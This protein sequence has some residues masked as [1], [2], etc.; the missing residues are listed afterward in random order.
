[1]QKKVLGLMIVLAV[2]LAACVPAA[3]PTAAPA[4]PAAPAAA[5]EAPAA[6]AA[7]AAATEAP[8]APAAPAA[9]VSV[10]KVGA[11]LPLTGGDA[12]NGQ[13]QQQAH[14]LAIEEINAAGGIAC[15]NGAKLEMVYGDSQGKPEAGNSETERL[16]TKEGVVAVMGAFHTGV[17]LT[18]SE[19]AERYEVPFIVPNSDVSARNLKYVFQPA[20]SIESMAKDFGCLCQG[21]G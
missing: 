9:E 18:A 19:V 20:T 12:I 21:D 1:M 4:A 5:T 6:P 7:P 17:T 8:A 11:L 13:S 3:T 2:M 16:I 10:I 15:M 14:E